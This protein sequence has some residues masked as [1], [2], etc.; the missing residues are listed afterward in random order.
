MWWGEAV[1]TQGEEPLST[2][3]GERPQGKQTLLMPWSP[4]F[5]L[6]NC[7]TVNICS[8]SCLT[9]GVLLQQPSRL[10]LAFA[11]LDL[12]L[13]I[14][15]GCP[16]PDLHGNNSWSFSRTLLRCSERIRKLLYTTRLGCPLGVP[17]A[18][19]E[20]L[21]NLL[22]SEPLVPS[23]VFGTQNMISGYELSVGTHASQQQTKVATESIII[24]ES[25]IVCLNQTQP[26]R[27]CCP[28]LLMW[29]S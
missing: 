25:T 8:L 21:S 24:T 9:Y 11:I 28:D 20:P 18:P 4:I 6:Q 26:W 19:G 29:I 2:H 23:V 7:D 17:S 13:H 12:P 27:G 3:Q 22:S 16:F 5:S 14:F 15:L 10:M 1:R